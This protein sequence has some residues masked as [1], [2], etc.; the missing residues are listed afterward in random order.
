[1][2]SYVGDQKLILLKNY[3]GIFRLHI[4][5][6]IFMFTLKMASSMKN[7]NIY[8]FINKNVLFDLIH[9]P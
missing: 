9:L 3:I 4:P 7:S 8:N 1:M 6:V 2:M 5:E